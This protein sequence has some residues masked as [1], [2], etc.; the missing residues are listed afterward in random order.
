MENPPP[1]SSSLLLLL[2]P[3]PSFSFVSFVFVTRIEEDSISLFLSPQS[4]KEDIHT[5][6]SDSTMSNHD[7][8]SALSHTFTD[9]R[10]QYEVECVVK[11]MV[12][13][14]EAWFVENKLRATQLDLAI[15][16]EQLQSLQQELVECEDEK[17]L[18]NKNINKMREKARLANEYIKFKVL[19]SSFL[20]RI[21][22]NNP[23]PSPPPPRSLK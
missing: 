11:D 10:T 12:N 5:F 8:V 3:P 23:P 7:L 6:E 14:I 4:S 15:T 19:S 16:T 9:L 13:D 2:F 18:L 17:I 22:L 1:F 21:N 20:P